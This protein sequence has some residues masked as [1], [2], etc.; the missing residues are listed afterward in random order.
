M[1]F[2]GI[3]LKEIS[4]IEKDECCIISLFVHVESVFY[5][6]VESIF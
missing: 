4:Q 3:M 5:V 2:K 6:N 1:D